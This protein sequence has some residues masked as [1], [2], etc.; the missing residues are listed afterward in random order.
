MKPPQ[1]RENHAAPENTTSE[2]FSTWQ[3]NDPVHLNN[4]ATET[5][6]F[7]QIKGD[8][9]EFDNFDNNLEYQ[10]HGIGEIHHDH[11]ISGTWQ[12]AKANASAGS[13][14]LHVANSQDRVRTGFLLGRTQD[15]RKNFGAWVLVRKNKDVATLDIAHQHLEKA[16]SSLASD[17]CPGLSD[18]VTYS[19][20][21][22]IGSFL[23]NKL[24]PAFSNLRDGDLIEAVRGAFGGLEAYVREKS[25]VA[26][27][28]MLDMM[29][30]AFRPFSG[31]LSNGNLKRTRAESSEQERM[32]DLFTGSLYV[33]NLYAHKDPPKLKVDGAVK[34]LIL[35]SY[36]YEL[37][38]SQ[39][40]KRR[41]ES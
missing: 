15:D 22:F 28:N 27:E 18:L 13:F 11:Y 17:M 3:T 39:A 19:N 36:F 6:K 12:S 34:L 14:M 8:L 40:E 37:V 4:W 1:I 2:W 41:D 7:R 38:D 29:T 21:K 23:H 26:V 25:G 9:F 5:I 33:R 31:K 20:G 35:A 30:S 24:S 16:K 10:W 32:Q